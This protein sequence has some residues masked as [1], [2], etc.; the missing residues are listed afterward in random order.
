M[1]TFGAQAKI[2]EP[3]FRFAERMGRLKASAIREILKIIDSSHCDEISIETADIKLFVRRSGVGG[4]ETTQAPS[5]PA[6][7]PSAPAAPPA[8][9][10][11]SVKFVRRFESE[12]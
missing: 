12:S 11:G 8:A 7:A 2:D 6:A 3:V 9:L 5:G 10:S 4:P 1:A